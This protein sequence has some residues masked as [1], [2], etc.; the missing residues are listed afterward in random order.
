MYAWAD[1]VA[2]S[3]RMR[4]GGS[5]GGSFQVSA[6]HRLNGGGGRRGLGS[7]AMALGL[8]AAVAG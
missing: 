4:V 1:V 3:G 5:D 7:R 8:A 2:Q 6:W